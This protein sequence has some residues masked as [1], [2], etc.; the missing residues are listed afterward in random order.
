MEKKYDFGGWATRNDLKCADG[1]TIRKDAFKH[2]DGQTVPLVWN[3]D[4]KEQESVLG[5]A[6]LENRDEGV[7]CYCSFNATERGQNAKMLV[8]H[9]DIGSLS[10]YANHLKQ[11]SNGDVLHG[12][13]REVSLVLAG[14]NP[15]A[16]IDTVLTHSEEGTDEEG[17]IYSG[18]SL[19]LEHSEE[20]IE[21]EKAD[22]TEES[23]I[24]E[25]LEH[26]E[27]AKE[28]NKKM[29]NEPK[30]K[31][32]Q[33]V[34]DSMTE[35]QKNVMYFI[36]GQAVEDAK[37]GGK[38]EGED[39]EMKHNIFENEVETT[40][41]VISHAD[42]MDTIADAKRFGSLRESALQHGITDVEYL[43]PDAKNL[44]N[45]PAFVRN[46]PS[47]WVSVVM[48]G[49]KHTPFSKVKMMF[50][51]IREDEARAKGFLKGNQ[52]VEEV[53]SLLKRTVDPTTVYKLQKMHRDDVLDITD[54]DV[55]AW[56]KAEMRM[57]L[58]EELARAYLFG[59]GRL[60]SSNDHIDATKII[61]AVS[62]AALYTVSKTVTKNAG[63]TDEHA[64]IRSTVEA[65]DDYQGSGNAI[66]F[67]PQKE[68]TKML[69]ME[70][71]LGHRLYK[72]L[73]DLA[74]AMLLSKIVK[75]PANI[76]P[77]GVKGLI[78]DL[79]DYNVGA[80]KGGSVNMFE[81]FDID[82]NKQAYLIETRCSGALV[83]PFAAI[84]LKEAQD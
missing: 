13:I 46:E 35:E 31:T 10:I 42:M 44:T 57:M 30:E 78:L 19:T 7:Y 73:A 61:P 64:F 22:E 62:D 40:E 39:E 75:V 18:E 26:K 48:K 55:V 36:V 2:C 72:N 81:D 59:D 47:E 14:A 16:Y 70:D 27:E 20:E 69:L 58:D 66:G 77:T 80:D 71:T 25:V 84:A 63:E 41:N 3:H 11:S 4:H 74:D 12:S 60:V 33:E 68:I 17:Y 56:L 6:L 8:Q 51:D 21:T 15:G 65:M 52:K 83:K 53:F 54:F 5:H 45:A 82:Y 67:F 76:V 43:F 49:V 37:K 1:R 50:A 32:V 34:V 29:A 38:E 28:E 9:G 79:S 24:E 23:E